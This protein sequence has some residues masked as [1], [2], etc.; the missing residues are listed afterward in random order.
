MC[1]L[2]YLSSS[3]FSSISLS[4]D[5]NLSAKDFSLSLI[6]I[7]YFSFSFLGVIIKSIGFTALKEL[8]SLFCSAI[9]DYIL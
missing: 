3:L 8:E 6:S 4:G 7:F 2:S 1:C 5:R 9:S